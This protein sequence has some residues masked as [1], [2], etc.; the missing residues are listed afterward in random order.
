METVFTIVFLGFI[1]GSLCDLVAGL[2]HPSRPTVRPRSRGLQ[3][4]SRMKRSRIGE[5]LR[6]DIPVAM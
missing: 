4:R 5:P 2:I 1:A 3:K 6:F